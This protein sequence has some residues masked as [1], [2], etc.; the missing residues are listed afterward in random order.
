MRGYDAY[1]K[2]LRVAAVLAVMALSACG[3]GSGNSGINSIAACQ[4]LNIPFLVYPVSGAH[5]QPGPLTVV[6]GDGQNPSLEWINAQFLASNGPGFYGGPYIA[7]GPG[8]YAVAS[9]G[10]LPLTAYTVIVTS[11]NCGVSE[12]IG[13]Y[14]S[15]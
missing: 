13:T 1:M 7:D 10:V 14:S 8:R 3:G 6:I 5:V 2:S 12:V 15:Q 9:P 11:R 4:G